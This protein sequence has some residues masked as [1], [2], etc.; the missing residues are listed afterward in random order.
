MVDRF[1]NVPKDILELIL[2]ET[3]P[4]NLDTFCQIND[5]IH[6]LCQD[7][8]I[9][10][11]YIKYHQLIAPYISI[12]ISNVINTNSIILIVYLFKVL[13]KPIDL[14]YNF[15]EIIVSLSNNMNISDQDILNLLHIVY[16]ILNVSNPSMLK[17]NDSFVQNTLIYLA[18]KNDRK[19]LI[20]LLKQPTNNHKYLSELLQETANF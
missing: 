20:E 16:S 1:V 12:T 3:D 2:Y 9:I 15:W 19:Y 4:K 6:N 13:S 7:T 17:L 5:R 14:V 11:R 8:E 18:K 10:N